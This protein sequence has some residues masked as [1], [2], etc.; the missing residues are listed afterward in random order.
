MKRDPQLSW[1]QNM[2]WK[3]TPCYTRKEKL[4]INVNFFTIAESVTKTR[5]ISSVPQE[6]E[7]KL[8]NIDKTSSMILVINQEMAQWIKCITQSGSPQPSKK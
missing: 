5:A 1:G 7:S 6:L 4:N 2:F 3:I 8:E